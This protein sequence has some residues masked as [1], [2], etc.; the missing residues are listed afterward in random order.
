MGCEFPEHHGSSGGGIAGA[1]VVILAAIVGVAIVPLIHIITMILAAVLGA[2]A[3]GAGVWAGLAIRSR[4]RHRE[5]GTSPVAGALTRRPRRPQAL[6]QGQEQGVHLHLHG[7]SPEAL[8]H[9][10]GGQQD[11]T[12]WRAEVLLP[13]RDGQR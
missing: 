5:A 9:I 8:R 4:V 11:A 1:L 3:L 10:L 13:R 12:T 6:P 7:V 2:A